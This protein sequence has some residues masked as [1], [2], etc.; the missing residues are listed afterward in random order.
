LTAGPSA[1]AIGL[2]THAPE[3]AWKALAAA[4][5]YIAIG[6]VYATGTKPGAKAVTLDYVRWA[7]SHVTIPWFAIG[8]IHLGNVD[9]VIAAGAKAVCAVSAILDSPDIAGTCREF[10]R[11]LGAC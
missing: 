11:R 3:Q 6:P 8:G 4:P 1:P 7:A 2:S 10:K 9:Q 5:A